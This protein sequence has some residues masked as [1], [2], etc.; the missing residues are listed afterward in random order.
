M[1]GT[2]KP[3]KLDENIALVEVS[4]KTKRIRVGVGNE[5]SSILSNTIKFSIGEG[6][7]VLDVRATQ[8]HIW[9]QADNSRMT[10]LKPVHETQEISWSQTYTY[11][12]GFNLTFLSFDV[13]EFD[14]KSNKESY[15][16]RADT[17]QQFC[18]D[19]TQHIFDTEDKLSGIN[20]KFVCSCSRDFTMDQT[21]GN[22]CNRIPMCFTHTSLLCDY[23]PDTTDTSEF[24]C[25]KERF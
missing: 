23:S 15:P 18:R 21:Y 17:C 10:V 24:K 9:I 25:V 8:N 20:G 11:D 6:Q 7:S 2:R 19:E 1:N 14:I 3:H 12:N 5:D 13:F 16:C 4:Q 22:V